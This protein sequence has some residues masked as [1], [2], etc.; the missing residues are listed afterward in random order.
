MLVPST[1]KNIQMSASAE[2]D[3]RK[4]SKKELLA[5]IKHIREWDGG[6]DYPIYVTRQTLEK[7]DVVE[8]EINERPF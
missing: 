5:Q 2:I 4:G 6:Y 7:I 3:L 8:K 1:F